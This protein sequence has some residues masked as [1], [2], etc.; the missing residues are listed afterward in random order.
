M[1]NLLPQ[2]C[3]V[4]YQLLAVMLL[5]QLNDRL[6]VAFDHSQLRTMASETVDPIELAFLLYM[7]AATR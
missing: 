6:P 7:R 3:G 1:E 4:N 2:F 5:K